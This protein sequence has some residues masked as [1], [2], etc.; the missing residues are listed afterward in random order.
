MKTLGSIV[1]VFAIPASILAA[2]PSAAAEARTESWVVYGIHNAADARH[3]RDALQHVPG[4]SYVSVSQATADVSFE[5][6][7]VTDA[8][9]VAAVAHAGDY[10][11]VRHAD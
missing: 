11:L 9:L 3:V 5:S 7:A 2:Q 6:E 1:A 8:Q 4:V 10:R